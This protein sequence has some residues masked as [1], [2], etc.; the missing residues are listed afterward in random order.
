METQRLRAADTLLIVISLFA[1][2]WKQT[3]A[4]KRSVIKHE[5]LIMFYC[6]PLTYPTS[7]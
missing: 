7:L 6:I 5:L 3:A 4:P 2:L 1:L